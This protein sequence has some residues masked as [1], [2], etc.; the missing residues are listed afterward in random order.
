[1]LGRTSGSELPT[2]D[3][4]EKVIMMQEIKAMFWWQS[5]CISNSLNVE[6]KLLR[7]CS[8]PSKKIQT[9]GIYVVFF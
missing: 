4:V 9:I 7:F 1:M 6:T 8:K 2:R 3:I 5:E